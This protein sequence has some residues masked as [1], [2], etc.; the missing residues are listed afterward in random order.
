MYSILYF[1]DDDYKE[2]KGHR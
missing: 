1:A 2:E